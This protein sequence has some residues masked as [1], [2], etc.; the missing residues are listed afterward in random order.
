MDAIKKANDLQPD[1]ITLDLMMPTMDGYF[2]TGLLKQNPKTR[3]IPIIIVSSV[4]E[5]EKCYRLGVTDYI[6]KP[7]DASAFIETIH[8]VEKHLENE[9]LKK[10]A[11]IVDADPN[12][13]SELTLS[14]TNRGY[15]VFSA[16][17]G[18]QAVAL[19]KKEK[20]GILILDA[21]LLEAGGFNIIKTIKNDPDTAA[22]PALITGKS[23]AAKEKAM[24]YSANGYLIKPFTTA[25][26][27]E[28]I[29]KIFASFS[30]S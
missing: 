16:Y 21:D 25:M 14:F 26:L 27:F 7:F 15:T 23:V 1:L 22:I 18:I 13:V 12:I 19:M 8:R 30:K 10:K 24:L 28:E 3:D 9:N 4:M 11:L 20:P 5:K 17:D 2:I 6:T 29:D